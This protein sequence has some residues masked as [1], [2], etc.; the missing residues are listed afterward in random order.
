MAQLTSRRYERRHRPLVEFV[1][2][3]QIP[4]RQS[5]TLFC[6]AESRQA[7]MA[8]FSRIVSSTASK[9]ALAI[10]WTTARS[11]PLPICLCPAAVAPGCM[12]DDAPE[13][14]VSVP[15]NADVLH[16]GKFDERGN[17]WLAD[18]DDGTVRLYSGESTGERIKRW[19]DMPSSSWKIV[20][21]HMR[22]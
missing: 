12:T 10:I 17:C 1:H 6:S 9:L 19:T 3:F 14:A 5:V 18:F 16:V 20:W 2:R 21:T 22:P 11:V 7:H 15:A 8:L 13:S 4:R